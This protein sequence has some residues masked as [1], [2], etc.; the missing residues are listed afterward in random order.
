MK[1]WWNNANIVPVTLYEIFL[2]VNSKKV[3]MKKYIVLNAISKENLKTLK[4]H[5]HSI[6]H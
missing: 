6:K 5:I 1:K 2:W 4:L 3:S